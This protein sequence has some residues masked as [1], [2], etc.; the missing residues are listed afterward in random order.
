[1]SEPK[2]PGPSGAASGEPAVVDP[3]SGATPKGRQIRPPRTV[4]DKSPSQLSGQGRAPKPSREPRTVIDT[5]PTPLAGQ[6]RACGC[7]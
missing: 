1:M 6:G 7:D 3:A 2:S 5:S 4:I